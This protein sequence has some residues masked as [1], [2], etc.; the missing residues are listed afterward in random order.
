MAD[1][2]AGPTGVEQV[3]PHRFEFGT[4][5]QTLAR[6]APLVRRSCI[7]PQVTFG[8]ADWRGDA[9]SLC[10]QIAREFAGRHLVVRSSARTEDTFETSHAGRYTSLLDVP[11]SDQAAIQEA[12][13]KVIA[14]YGEGSPEDQVL[15]QP[16]VQAIRLSGVLFTR[17]LTTLAPYQTFEYDDHS[18]RSDTVTSGRG[19]NLKAYVRF[20][21]ATCGFDDDALRA[22][23]DAAGEIEDLVGLDR[24]EI[25]LAVDV[26]GTVWTLQVRPIVGSAGVVPDT[27]IR[28][29]YL[30]KTAK[31]VEKLSRAHP[32]LYGTRSV[33]GVMPDWNPAEII[34]LRPRML[35]LSL[36]KEIITDSIWAYQRDNY[37]YRNLR[38]FPLL[39]SL[40]GVPFIDV[41]VSFN[42]FIPKGVTERLAEKL[43]NYYVERLAESPDQHDKVEFDILFTCF[44]P[45][46][47]EKVAVLEE[48]GFTGVEVG[49]LLAALRVLTNKIL[50]PASGLY[51][52]DLA[53]LEVLDLRWRQVG[54]SGM[55][56]VDQIYWLLED[57]K[58]YGTLPFSGLAR[59]GFI[60]MQ[61]LRGF[62]ATDIFTPQDFGAFMGSLDTVAN[63][64]GRDLA[65]L[66]RGE[67]GRDAFLAQYGHLRP[68]TYDILSSRYDVGFERYFG[69]L[70]AHDDL[71]RQPFHLSAEQ[72]RRI[73]ELL[74]REGIEITAGHL[75]E[76]LHLAI[77]GREYAKLIFT[78]NLSDALELLVALG[79]QCH[80]TRDD[81][82]HLNIRVVQQLYSML[83]AW[84]LRDV[85]LRDIEANRKA[86]EVTRL[87][88]FPQL[89]LSPENVFHFHRTPGQ[90]NF[91]TQRRV[92]AEV[93]HGDLHQSLAGR[94]VCV[95]SADP[96][97][98]W[99]FSKRIAGL[100][101]LFG[102]ANSHMAI[103][104]AEQ[105]VP[106]VIGSG[107]V[108][109]KSW[110]QAQLLDLDCENRCVTVIR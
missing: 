85:L 19:R 11:A 31:K 62:V 23:F 6:L 43:A 109:F 4:K 25:E 40:L 5:A 63:R 56:R 61:Y 73:D 93:V 89:L 88:Q 54:A 16:Q 9:S 26:A 57:C 48:H 27:R 84:D 104:A 13:A 78:R 21:G 37:D 80:L 32:H 18:R 110:S 34:G 91:V 7:Q 38:S 15:V 33:F 68:G 58:R 75:M 3:P 47:R 49:E 97:Y 77:E 29:D 51:R 64:M 50:Q 108:N 10:H 53:K 36:Y 52:Q 82:S 55:S 67:I 98:D 105:D 28:A 22:V 46:I 96:G 39:V 106:A 71:P 100:V 83:D 60:A 14:S 101:T 81:L 17:D 20:R 92:A 8:V 2:Y 41:R 72:R 45:G 87:V 59:A 107:E 69:D 74:A 65:R 1:D 76:F 79:E 12:V 102:G 103:R 70:A 86:Y 99:L 35:A 24:L 95:P 90:P 66:S 94:I 30:E 44:Y 42:S